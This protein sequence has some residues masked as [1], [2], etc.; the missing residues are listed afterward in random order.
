MI[1]RPQ[2]PSSLYLCDPEKSFPWY[3]LL[4]WGNI[5]ITKGSLMRGL[6][7][8]LVAL[9]VLGLVVGCSTGQSNSYSGPKPRVTSTQPPACVTW[10]RT[11]RG[12]Y[13]ATATSAPRF[14]SECVD[15]EVD[16]DGVRYCAMTK[17]EAPRTRT[18]ASTTGETPTVRTSAPGPRPRHTSKRT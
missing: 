15:W 13:C 10:I 4:I 18:A 5:H 16:R 12:A 2:R 9:V 14:R 6:L 7:R 11:D 17:E 8:T 1:L 3:P